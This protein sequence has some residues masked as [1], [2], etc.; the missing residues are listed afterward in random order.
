VKSQSLSRQLDTGF[1]T[2][3][4][5]VLGLRNLGFVPFIGDSFWVYHLHHAS[6]R[7]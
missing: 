6:R 2:V 5:V 3:Y 4:K 7:A 1:L